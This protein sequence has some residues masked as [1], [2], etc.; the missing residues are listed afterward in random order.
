MAAAKKF[1]FSF[2]V[3]IDLHL[4]SFKVGGFTITVNF[5]LVMLLVDIPA[6]TLL[7]ILLFIDSSKMGQIRVNTRSV[8]KEKPYLIKFIGFFFFFF[9]VTGTGTAKKSIGFSSIQV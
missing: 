3:K 8:T 5:A 4:P 1:L 7:T 2:S 9:F 6:L